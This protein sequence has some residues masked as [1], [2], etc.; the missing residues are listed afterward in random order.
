LSNLIKLI[1]IHTIPTIKPNEI[2]RSK[3]IKIE[4]KWKFYKNFKI[5][6]FDSF[7]EHIKE[8]GKRQTTLDRIDNDGNYCKE[9]CRWATFKEQANNRISVI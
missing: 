6:M 9:N 3:G 4:A 7:L 8:Y 5:D 1:I 2:K